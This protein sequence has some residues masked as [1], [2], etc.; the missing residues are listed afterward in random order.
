MEVSRL[1]GE[2]EDVGLERREKEETHLIGLRED[3]ESTMEILAEEEAITIWNE[4]TEKLKKA[5]KLSMK[6]K[7]CLRMITMMERLSVN[8]ME[9]DWIETR[10]LEMMPLGAIM[11]L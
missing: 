10:I 7:K 6:H 11:I 3:G 2:V 5:R 8:N 4:K 9:M 1:I